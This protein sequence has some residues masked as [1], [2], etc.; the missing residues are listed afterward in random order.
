VISMEMTKVPFDK[1]YWVVPGKFLAGCYP[2]AMRSD[3]EQERKLKALLDAG[4]R[5]IVNLMHDCETEWAVGMFEGYE[6]GLC[7][8]AQDKGVEVECVRMP[9]PDMSILSIIGMKEILDKID[10]AIALGR[11][12]YVHCWEGRGRAG[13]VVGCYL[14]RH[15]IAAGNQALAMIQELRKNSCSTFQSSPQNER[16]KWMV[17]LWKVGE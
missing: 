14:V 10:A 3:D 13:T 9:I 15:G 12:V 16:Q 6:K 1:S 7:V 11:P 8:L 5:C 2:G 17:R 4:I